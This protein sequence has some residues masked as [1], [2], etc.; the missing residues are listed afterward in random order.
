[1]ALTSVSIGSSSG[2]DALTSDNF[3]IAGI[4]DSGSTALVLP[5]DLFS[6]I[7]EEVGATVIGGNLALVPCGLAQ[8]AGNLTFG[9]AGPNGPSIVAPIS[10]FVNPPADFGMILTGVTAPV[11]PNNQS[12]CILGISPA[13]TSPVVFGDAFL[14]SAYVVFDLA[15][16]RIGMAQGNP[17]DTTGEIIAFSSSGAPI[18]SAMTVSAEVTDVSSVTITTLSGVSSDASTSPVP[19]TLT[20]QPIPSGRSAASGLIAPVAAGASSK[21]P[22]GTATAGVGS[23][24]GSSQTGA[25]SVLRAGG[26]SWPTYSLGVSVLVC[27]IASLQ[28]FA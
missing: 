7:V 6:A 24:T 20:F 12:A 22:N 8:E 18:P 1:M 19:E 21:A 14:Q 13:G 23:P 25:A 10:G 2:T 11:Y 15:N 3:S 28:L 27:M 16:Q 26:M 9:F 17:V 4:L 5:D